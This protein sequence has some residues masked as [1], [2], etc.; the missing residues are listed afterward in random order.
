ME[1]NGSRLLAR[2]LLLPLLLLPAP[3]RRTGLSL[4][5]LLELLPP[6][7]LP[8]ELL[9]SSSLLLLSRRRRAPAVGFVVIFFFAFT[10]EAAA[11]AS[12]ARVFFPA[13]P[14]GVA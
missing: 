14:A 2:P 6:P 8:L 5:L 10:V 7:L 13:A 4:E 9:P 1:K 12:V 11:T 3:T